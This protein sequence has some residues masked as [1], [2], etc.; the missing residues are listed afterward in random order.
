MLS[1]LIKP[2]T[3]CLCC[4]LLLIYINTMQRISP[5]P[6][7]HY[8]STM[9][10]IFVSRT[11]AVAQMPGTHL[12]RCISIVPLGEIQRTL[13]SFRSRD[14]CLLQMG[15]WELTPWSIKTFLFL[16]ICCFPELSLLLNLKPFLKK[17]QTVSNDSMCQVEHRKIYRLFYIT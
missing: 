5:I 8:F 15:K 13:K 17:A 11:A 2:D 12:I 1:L 16:A 7:Q 9:A 4:I 3:F 14:H 6:Q 10:N